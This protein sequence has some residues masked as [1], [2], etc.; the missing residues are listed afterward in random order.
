MPNPRSAQVAAGPGKRFNL[1]VSSLISFLPCFGLLE[2]E[3]AVQITASSL[4]YSRGPIHFLESPGSQAESTGVG[5]GGAS[6]SLASI[7]SALGTRRP[8]G[9]LATMDRGHP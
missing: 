2:C 7:L 5:V 9:G 3:A 4:C 1:K 8:L 6:A